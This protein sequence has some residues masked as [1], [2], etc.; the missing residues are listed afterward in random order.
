MLTSTCLG[1]FNRFASPEGRRIAY[2]NHGADR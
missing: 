2:F 1:C